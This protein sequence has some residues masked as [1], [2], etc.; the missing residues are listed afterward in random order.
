M[1]KLGSACREFVHGRNVKAS[2]VICRRLP[3]SWPLLHQ[4]SSVVSL[5]RPVLELLRPSTAVL[6]GAPPAV[7]SLGYIYPDSSRL[8]RRYDH[9]RMWHFY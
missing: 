7:P 4:W 9:S 5:I 3:V 8:R 1:P 6:S 2:T